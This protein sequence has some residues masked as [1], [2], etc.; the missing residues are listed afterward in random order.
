MKK[1]ILSMIIAIVMVV[2]LVPSF[3][4]AASAATGV[5]AKGTLGQY[6]RTA[7]TIYDDG[8]LVIDGKGNT[9]TS[10]NWD[11]TTASPWKSYADI[12]TR[13]SFTNCENWTSLPAHSFKSLR[14]LKEIA[15]P[16][17]LEVIQELALGYTGIETI[18][19]PQSLKEI[20]R[21]A[22]SNCE[23]LNYVNIHSGIT[24]IDSDAFSNCVNLKAIS[25]P[26]SVTSIGQT[27]F[28]NCRNLE[29]VRLSES[30]DK[31]GGSMFSGCTML[32]NISLPSSVTTIGSKAFF[33]ASNLASIYYHGVSEPTTYN[34]GLENATF[35]LAPD[36]MVIYA[37]NNYSG[38]TM[39]LKKNWE[40]DVQTVTKI[41]GYFVNVAHTVG[42]AVKVD[43]SIVSASDTVT[44][45]IMSYKNFA[46]DTFVVKGTDGN[47]IAVNGDGNTRTFAMPA[48]DVTITATFK[49]TIVPH[50]HSWSFEVDGTRIN[51]TCANSDGMC[52][53]PNQSVVMTAPTTK[54]FA[55]NLERTVTVSG[56]IEDVEVS[57]V[58]YTLKSTGKVARP[59]APGVY[60]ATI[61][62]GGATATCEY[63]I[64]KSDQLNYTFFTYI[65]PDNL[66]YDGTAKVAT[67]VL[68]ENVAPYIGDIEVL[69][70]GRKEAPVNKGEYTVT[71]NVAESDYYSAKIGIVLKTG[72]G[73]QMKDAK[74]TID[75][76]D[77]ADLTYVLEDSYPLIN[78][79]ATPDIT[80]QYNG[81]T[82]VKDTDYTLAY[83]NNTTSESLATVTVNGIGNYS[84]TKELTFMVDAEHIHDYTNSTV[85]FN[86]ENHW[87]ECD[88][89]NCPDKVGSRK[90]I[91]EH[92]ASADDGDCTTPL[93]CSGCDH[94]VT[95]ARTTHEAGADDGDC[96]TA[97]ICKHCT[98]VVTDGNAT[99]T[100]D[101]DDGDCTTDINCK[102]CT[103]VAVF[104]NDDHTPELD[105]GDCTTDIKCSI[106][107]T[108]TT[109]GAA[110]HT[111]GT[112]TC[113]A[114]AKCDVCGKEYGN[115]TDHT[116]GTE[117]KN[118]ADNHWN[119]CTCGDKANVAAHADSNSDEKCDTCGKEMLAPSGGD[120]PGTDEPGTDE[121]GTDEPGTDDPNANNIANP[122]DET[123]GLETGAI[124]AIA[125]GSTVVGGAG[126]F[127]LV[128]F[129]IKKKTWADLLLIFKK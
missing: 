100:P 9:M 96:T 86:D 95:A 43:K 57:D 29:Y 106:C 34:P 118:D 120:E 62:V 51:A 56:T 65:A 123:D 3:A 11:S 30:V 129:V 102:N 74:F 69:Y 60:V 80:I 4:I 38:T 113:T 24:K 44:V 54:Y 79:A 103:K 84:G 15:L 82:L 101:L 115:T 70:N 5:Y 16:E 33:K 18:V 75:A 50:V 68:S 58:V 72:S 119:E 1:R 14:N 90:D 31:I 83:A 59:F 88:D 40:N 26:D 92:T 42:G 45:D 125:A 48:G 27:L 35:S 116:H 22:F 121:P 73:R 98:K 19:L 76:K 104:G 2:G 89:V 67:A 97:I 6:D 20:G 32:K 46:L 114:K 85:G 41:D 66:T 17:N 53:N 8:L 112:A 107:E 37:S 109:E 39:G 28:Q 10:V 105:D 61:T 99:H 13:I 117:W 36:T 63:E 110:T 94:I 81:M 77:I 93:L 124:V 91:T 47:A 64:T 7:W 127:A 126:I 128:W 87:I 23:A 108:V 25:I 49:S 111:G 71:I 122:T 21:A 55:W 52:H 12:I 78:G